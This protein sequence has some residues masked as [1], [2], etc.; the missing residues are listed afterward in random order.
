M[1]CCYQQR[2]LEEQ[3]PTVSVPHPEFLGKTHAQKGL[4]IRDEGL[5]WPLLRATGKK[6]FFSKHAEKAKWKSNL[7]LVE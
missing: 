1:L 6:D 7:H 4:P 5:Y 3:L 2:R